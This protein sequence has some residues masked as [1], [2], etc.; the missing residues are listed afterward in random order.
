MRR[1]DCSP[2]LFLLTGLA[3]LIVASLVGMAGFLGIVRGTSLPTWLRL[4]HV[5][6]ALVGGVAQLILGGMLTFIPTLLMTGQ[7][8]SDSHPMLYLAIN[9]GTIGLLIGFGLHNHTVVSGAG[10]LI[11]VAFLSVAGDAI[12]Q[13]KASL[14]SPPLNLWF[15][16]LALVALFAGL[17]L[18][19]G[20]AFGLFTG[21]YGHAR[22]SH[23]HL[24][25]LG[26]V[27]LTIIGTMHNLLPTVL[28]TP[29]Y[30]PGLARAVFILWPAGLLLLIGGFSQSSLWSEIAGGGVLIVASGAYAYN[31][32]K[33]WLNAGAQETAASDHL[34]VATL[35]LVIAVIMGV[36]VG[37]NLLWDPP[38]LPFGT[39]HL[40][41]YT[42][43]ALVGFVLQTIVGALSHLLPVTLAVR[44]VASH[45]KRS[46]Y[47]DQLTRIVNRWRAVQI[48]SLSLGTM[49][50]AVVASLT[51]SLPLHAPTIQ[52]SAWISFILLLFSLTLFATKVAHLLGKQPA[53]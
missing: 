6:G 10:V 51:W 8:R 30:S 32:L 50:L 52:V 5:H 3:W 37:V 14:N 41:A 38:A 9:G 44:R 36:L 45:K 34:L 53:K 23:I 21:W 11:I 20:M 29:L 15:Y 42:H 47:L 7:K 25:L 2:M 1:L 26:F 46:P 40:V 39:L 19:V 27:T 33:T 13:A 49:G 22:L 18:G 16:G 4:L 43:M 28:Q 17:A 31:M 35:F 24:N 48:G 12:R